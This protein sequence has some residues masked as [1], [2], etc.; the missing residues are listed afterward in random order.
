MC[1]NWKRRSTGLACVLLL[2]GC[3]ANPPLPQVTCP[4]IQPMPEW[5]VADLCRLTGIT[6]PPC[7]NASSSSGGQKSTGIR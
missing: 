4:A 3:A 7:G 2:G 1:A 5:A 6:D